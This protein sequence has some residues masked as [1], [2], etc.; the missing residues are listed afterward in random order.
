MTLHHATVGAG[1]IPVVFLHGLFGQ[2]KNFTS[3]AQGLSDVATS[4]L[5]DLPNHG[6]SPWTT[7][8]TLDNQADEVAAWVAEHFP[9]GVAVVGH[10]LGGKLA[11]RLALRS[12]HLVERLMVVDISPAENE[13]VESFGHLV[14]AMRGLALED[15]TSRGAAD[16]RL[17]DE[18]PDP[19]VRGF[20]LQNLR[21][22]DDSWLWQCNLELLGDSLAAIGGWPPV[23][24][25]NEALTY[26]VAGG[27]S[28][29]IRD[30]HLEPMRALFPRVV[31]MTLK[32]AGHWVHAEQPAAFTATVRHFL[33]A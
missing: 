16:A 30:D 32:N 15:V 10:S 12:A 9:D 23:E 20:L 11:M 29:Y 3:I 22:A 18:I 14:S 4:W 27:N 8:F 33:S 31:A 24:G 26:W 1:D 5:V 17:R 2:G 7:D 25:S 21:R 6:R 19:G 13:A 28:D